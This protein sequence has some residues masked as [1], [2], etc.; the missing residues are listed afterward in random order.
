MCATQGTNRKAF[1]A[2]ALRKQV[3]SVS[4]NNSFDQE[5]PMINQ[6]LGIPCA[7][8]KRL[9]GMRERAM[10]LVVFLFFLFF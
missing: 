10:K 2:T 6:Q 7:G 8:G 1:Q 9:Q 4:G 5:I 3:T